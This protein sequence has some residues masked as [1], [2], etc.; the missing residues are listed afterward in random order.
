MLLLLACTGTTE[1]SATTEPLDLPAD[2]AEDGVPVGVTTVVDGEQTYEIWYPASDSTTGATESPDFD[3]FLPEVFL[4]HVG[5]VSFPTFD[6][7]AVRDA[8]LRVPDE[9][10][11][12][13]LFSHGFGG[14]RLQSIDYTRHL[15]S[16]GYVVVAAD[17]PGRMMG[18]VLPCL[19]SPALDGCDLGGM[20]GDDPAEEDLAD[21]LAWVD[22]A[23]EDGFF[24]GALD[25][26]RLGLSGHSAGA[27]STITV[28]ESEERFDALLPMAGFA[29][30]SRDVPTL[31]MGGTC[32]TFATDTNAVK[33]SASLQTGGLLRIFGAG[34]LAFSDL[35]EL[36][37]AGNA[38]EWLA[39]RDDLNDTIY[40]LLLQLATDGCPDAAVPSP[41]VCDAE[42]FLDL[43]T[44]ARIVRDFSTR[45]FD[46][47][48]RD[49]AGL[50][51]GLY[52]EAEL[53]AAE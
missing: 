26:E 19:F 5:A 20:T 28:G 2:P 53:T 34:H 15:A 6:S 29:A 46:E 8:P 17:H 23:A 1:D 13:V 12:V 9:P 33:A 14:M 10:Y 11:P 7:G 45:F 25:T 24:A 38:D 50:E 31:M 18:D 47:R 3:Q 32:D 16:R 22:A 27:G 41:K 40:A 48:L 39:G 37:L 35:C 52:A 36:D 42:E 49:G 51:A 43:D 44:S 21:A 4:E 30:P